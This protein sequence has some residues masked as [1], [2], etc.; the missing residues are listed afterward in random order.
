MTDELK[1]WR[2]LESRELLDASP[3]MSVSVDRVELPDGRVVENFY[4]LRQPAFVCIFP[5]MEDGRVLAMRQYRHGP[6][7]VCLTFPG[8]HMDKP[9]ES[10]LETAKRELMEETG[11]VAERWTDLGAYTMYA[12]AGGATSH[13]FH[14]TGCRRVAEPD[15]GDLEETRIELLTKPE[16]LAAAG[17]GEIALMTQ[18]TLLAMVTSPDLV[19]AI[20]KV[21]G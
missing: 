16:L 7:R 13:M 2:V 4:Q 6:K 18:I 8:G 10:P 1:P 17:R 12:N 3:W 9:G 21:A 14:A 20:G 5:E 11:C 15:S 19:A